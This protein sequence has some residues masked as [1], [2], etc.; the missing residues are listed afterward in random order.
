ML[1]IR[2]FATDCVN[3]TFSVAVHSI[4]KW[5]SLHSLMMMLTL[6]LFL[7]IDYPLFEIQVQST[8]QI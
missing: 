6:L 3:I 5:L 2:L 7:L 8:Q 1:N 4:Q